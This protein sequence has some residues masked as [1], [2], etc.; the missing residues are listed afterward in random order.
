[1]PLISFPLTLFLLYLRRNFFSETPVLCCAKS[2]S[3]VW[4]FATPWTIATRLLCPWGF[5][6]QAYWSGYPCPHP[7]D[8]PNS[9]MEPRSPELQADSLPSELQGK[10]KNTGVG[11]PSLLQGI[12]PTQESNQNLLHCSR[13]FPNWATIVQLIQDSDWV[14]KAYFIHSST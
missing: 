9:R 10:P 1:M 12:F 13:S 8:L 14:L 7:R 11:S 3:C 4:L 2:L 6:R 5:S